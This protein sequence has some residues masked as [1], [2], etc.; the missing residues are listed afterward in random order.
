MAV[1]AQTV[2]RDRVTWL[3][4]CVENELERALTKFGTFN[5]QHEGK[6]VIE[7][8]LDE[9]WEHVK[10]NTGQGTKAMEEA[11]QVAAMALRY[12]HDLAEWGPTS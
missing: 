3:L 8:E 6:A 7:E 10:A 4:G 9:L 11:I 1:D 12:V 5:S 2:S